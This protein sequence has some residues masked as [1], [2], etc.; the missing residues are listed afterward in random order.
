MSTNYY[1]RTEQTPADAE[2]IH[3][4]KSAAGWPFMFRA[5]VDPGERNPLG[6]TWH[7]A[8]YASWLRLLDLGEIVNE[9]G[10]TVRREEL[11]GEIGLTHHLR[12]YHPPASRGDWDDDGGHRFTPCEFC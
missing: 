9:Y 10:R 6:I 1:I 7:V 2:G 4:G 11:L 12:A 3:L 8:D 5:Y